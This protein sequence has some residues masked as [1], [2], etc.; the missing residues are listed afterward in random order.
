QAKQLYQAKKYASARQILDQYLTEKDIN[1]ENKTEAEYLRAMSAIKLENKDAEGLL[2][3]FIE[4]HP[5]KSRSKKIYFQLAIHQFGNKSYYTAQKTFTKVNP[6]LLT[7]E[8]LVE[9]YFKS[10]YCHYKRKNYEEAQEAF[11]EIKDINSIYSTQANYYYSYIAYEKG[12]YQD[13]L[14][15]F[16]KLSSNPKYGNMVSYYIVHIYFHQKKYDEIIASGTPLLETINKKRR[17]ELS[18]L[19]GEA[20]YQKNHYDKAIEYFEYYF[21]NTR[22]RIDAEVTY[23]LAFVYYQTEH[24]QKAIEK[25]QKAGNNNSNDTLQQ[26]AFYHLGMCYVKTDQKKFAGNAFLSAYKIKINNTLRE[27]ALYSFVKLSYE[28]PYTPYNNAFEAIQLFIK[29]FPNSKHLDEINSF[30]VDIFLSSKDYQNA[31]NAFKKINNKTERLKKAYQKITYYRGVE[32]FNN[33]HYFEAIGLFKESLKYKYDNNTIAMCKYWTA[34]SYYQKKSYDL[35]FKSFDDFLHTQGAYGLSEYPTAYYNMGYIAFQQKQYNKAINFFKKYTIGSKN[36]KPEIIHDAFIRLGDCYFISKEYQKA[37]EYYD[38]AIVKNAVDQDYAIYQ[39][40]LAFGGCGE[41]SKKILQLDHLLRTQ[42]KSHFRDDA[43]YEIGLTYLL[44]DNNTEAIKHFSNVIKQFPT[45]THIKKAYLKSG[46]IY[47]NND[48]NKKALATLKD[49]AKKYSGTIEAH[50]ALSIIKNIYVDMNNVDGYFAFAKTLN[51]NITISEQDSVTYIA[52]ENIYMKGDYN[53]SIPEFDNYITKF[54][55]GAFVLNAHFYKAQ[56]EYKNK[57]YE[58]ALGDYEFVIAQPLSN[59]TESALA[60]ASTIIYDNKEYKK[61]HNYF[62]KLSKLAEYKE[63]I[64]LASTGLMRTNYHL[65]NYKEAIAAST[66]LLGDKKVNSKIKN[67]AHLIIAR[68]AKELGDNN[69]AKAEYTIVL[70]NSKSET[71]AEAKYFIAWHEYQNENFDAAEKIIFEISEEFAAYDYWLAKSFILL[72]DVYVKTKNL[73]QA[74]QTLQSIIENYSGKEL[75]DIAIMKKQK[76][77]KI[78]KKLEEQKLQEEQ[79][80]KKEEQNVDNY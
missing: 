66:L 22:K 76:I 67:E 16:Q 39:K 21:D 27:D 6:N 45:S 1:I 60:K 13:A 65:K 9:Y 68:S 20:W 36:R 25:F 59:F 42:K 41:L 14:A 55:Q 53:R 73:F 64:Q 37:I 43:E 30:L 74:K 33:R 4:Q 57:E 71:G 69:K 62:T 70:K 38:K 2:N 35:A 10:G 49:I 61:S 3:I 26:N 34:E 11:L 79:K 44:Q 32:I 63:N 46:L 47:Y 19:I 75:L 40:A 80:A 24:Y 50:E 28:N 78:E 5:E 56:C 51:S 15:G 23:Q 72:S 58:K 7:N 54:P 29:E 17:P 31:I 52:A 18:H 77:E 12:D 8:E 48:Q